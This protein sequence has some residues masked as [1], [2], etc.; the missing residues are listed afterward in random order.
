MPAGR[1]KI[2]IDW[3]K[4][5]AMCR[6]QC[7]GEE[8]ADVLGISYDTLERACKREKEVKFADYIAQKRQGGKAALRR[9]Q[10]KNAEDG[11]ATMQ[12]WLGK[13]ILDQ[14][15]KKEIDLTGKVDIHISADDSIVL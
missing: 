7:T 13:N 9:M 11:N 1:P 6:I 4:V 12:I 15:D 8:I 5:D 2:I 3:Q 10:W 14:V